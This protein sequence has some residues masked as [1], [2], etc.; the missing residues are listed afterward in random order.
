M[1]SSDLSLVT[2]LT[3]GQSHEY[4]YTC[5]SEVIQDL[6]SL[7]G[8]MSWYAARCREVSKPRDSGL[9]FFYHWQA[10]RQ[11]RCR[12]ACQISE[13]YD[14]YNGHCRGFETSCRLVNKAPEGNGQIDLYQATANFVSLYQ[15]YD[16][17]TLKAPQH[18]FTEACSNYINI[19]AVTCAEQATYY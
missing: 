4:S 18:N 7:S 6:Y 10:P 9:D 13:R 3:L 19:D 8:R 2:L 17:E 12:V 1:D 11:E 15:T 14:H 16:C 5:T